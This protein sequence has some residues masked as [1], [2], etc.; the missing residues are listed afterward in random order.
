MKDNNQGIRSLKLSRRGV[1]QTFIAGAA[2][3]YLAGCAPTNSGSDNNV[4]RYTTSWDPTSEDPRAKSQAAIIAAFTKK[5]PDIQVELTYV[6]WNQ[7]HTTLI[8]AAEAGR[9]PDVSLQMDSNLLTLIEQDSIQPITQ[10]TEGWSTERKSDYLFPFE[11]MVFDG[12]Q[13]AFRQSP[14]PGNVLFYRKDVFDQEG[15]KPPT[16]ADEWSAVAKQLSG[17]GSVGFGV[18]LGSTNDMNRFI[19]GFS[20]M[21]WARGGDLYDV[22]SKT[23]KF[24]DEPGVFALDW[25]RGMLDSGAI[26]PSIATSS[27]ETTDQQFTAGTT[28]T[29]IANA[30]NLGDYRS[31]QEGDWVGAAPFPNFANDASLPGAAYLAGGWTMVM[32]KGANE[33]VAWKFLEFY[34]DPE[35]EVLKATVGNELPTRK[36]TLEDPFFETDGAAQMRVWLDWMAANPAAAP[37]KV[38]NYPE[39]VKSVYDAV[40]EVLV[41]GTSAKD[42]LS[43]AQDRYQ[44]I[45][46]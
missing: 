15:L 34:Q 3:I 38:P 7:S 45:I 27:A 25:L 42:A 18:P 20:S 46:G 28:R 13:Y 35:A 40:Q 29:T 21:L 14:R 22:D 33:E 36:S 24:A 1:L 32:P 11:D 19:A 6:P 2:T 23:A 30:G 44:A 9:A 37:L 12:D 10:Y 39:L 43:G 8:L 4:L 41:N 31:R 26:S 17:S 16:T 5:Y